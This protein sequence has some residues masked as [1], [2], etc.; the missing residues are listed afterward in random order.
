MIQA[1]EFLQISSLLSKIFGNK[2]S[3][4]GAHSN[5]MKLFSHC[6]GTRVFLLFSLVSSFISARSILQSRGSSWSWSWSYGSWIY[7][8]LC[9]Q[10]LS[11]LTLWVQNPVQGEVYSIQHYVIKFVSNLAAGQW[12]SPGMPVSSTNKT[13]RHNIAEILLK[14]AL[15]TLT[16][17][18]CFRIDTI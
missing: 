17:T 7:K 15:N 2:M 4:T 12:F 5:K 14:V 9:N 1:W 13:D 10:C 8:Y 3:P 18:L 16:L 11:P 6:I